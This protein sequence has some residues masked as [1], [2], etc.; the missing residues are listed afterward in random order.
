MAKEVEPEPRATL[1]SSAEKKSEAGGDAPVCD[2]RGKPPSSSSNLAVVFPDAELVSKALRSLIKSEKSNLPVWFLWFAQ[3]VALV[4]NLIVI[5]GIFVALYQL[6]QSDLFEKRRTAIEAV[7]Q[8]RSPEFLQAFKRFTTNSYTEEE[9]AKLRDDDANYVTNTYAH[10]A[11]LYNNGLAD[12][13][14]I[15]ETC[16]LAVK[17]VLASCGAALCSDVN[18]AIIDNLSHTM[19]Q[20]SCPQSSLPPDCLKPSLPSH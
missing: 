11:L 13:C 4:S 3:L 12:K 6:R 8:V 20:E 2:E 19:E 9:A 16:C 10:I 17:K 1:D 15:K 14:V 7:N 18:K 5:G